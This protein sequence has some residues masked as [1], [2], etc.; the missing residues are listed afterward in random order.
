M[1]MKLALSTG[2]LFLLLGTIAPAYAQREEQQ[3]EQGKPQQGEQHQQEKAAPQQQPAGTS[4]Q[5]DGPSAEVQSSA[6]QQ[7]AKSFWLSQDSQ[8]ENS[9]REGLLVQFS[10]L[11][12]NRSK[13]SSV[14]QHELEVCP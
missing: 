1:P 10:Y 8:E 5:K 3:K 9:A 6:A 11:E 4:S 14:L 7:A 2:V 12:V 13:R